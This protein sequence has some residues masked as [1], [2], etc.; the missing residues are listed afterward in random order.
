M[1]VLKIIEK[2]RFIIFKWC[3]RLTSMHGSHMIKLQLFPLCRFKSPSSSS[4]QIIHGISSPVIV[5]LWQESVSA[6]RS[7]PPSDTE[8]YASGG[9][10]SSKAYID[11]FVSLTCLKSVLSSLNLKPWCRI[12]Q[13][14]MFPP[15]YDKLQQASN[16]RY[17]RC[18]GKII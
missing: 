18:K 6:G 13:R 5:H 8:V 1:N 11:R 15:K 16:S 10:V 3:D 7:P 4:R 17:L 2:F 9:S 14:V 12:Q